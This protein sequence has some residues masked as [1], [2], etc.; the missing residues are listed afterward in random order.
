MI[1]QLLLLL[2]AG[3]APA[4][5]SHA[6]QPLFSTT[7]LPQQRCGSPPIAD[8]ELT[9]A[10][11][12]LLPHL[13]W[14]EGEGAA[15]NTLPPPRVLSGV[16]AGVNCTVQQWCEGDTCTEVCARGSVQV[17]RWLS[18]AI[19]Q[20]SRLVQT[21]PLCYA[22]LLGTHNS[23]ITLAD[24]YGALDEYFR[25]FFKYI[26]W[27]VKDFRDAPLHTNNQLL[28]LT[29][30][31]NL[32]VRSLEIDTHWVGGIL[33]I[34]H[35]GGLHM[36]QLNKLIEAINFIAKLLHR[37]IR[38]DTETLGCVP[39]LSSIPAMD[40]RLLTDALQ[41]V[42]D[43][44]DRP[45]NALEFVILYFDDQVNLQTWGVVGNLLADITGIFPS[46]WVYTT[47]DKAAHGPGWPSQQEMLTAGKRLL[48]VSGTD[49]GADMQP[50]IFSRGD[51]LCGWNEP[52]LASVNGVPECHVGGD[53]PQARPL[54]D[55]LLTR[56]ISCELVYGPLNCDFVWRGTNQP[57]FDEL[58]LPPVMGCGLNMPSPDLLTPVR[59]AAAIWTWAPGHPFDPSYGDA[60]RLGELLGA[61]AGGSGSPSDSGV[62][63]SSSSGPL[64]SSRGS[65]VQALAANC[66]VISAADARW[67]AVPCSLPALPSACRD[68]N[69]SLGAPDGGW[70]V[71]ASLPRGDC[72]PG[73]QYDLPRHP[74]ENYLLAAA[75]QRAGHEAAWLPV[76]G[77][78]WSTDGWPAERQQRQPTDKRRV[79]R[80]VALPAAGGLLAVA[81]LVAG[82]VLGRRLWL[83]C[84]RGGLYQ[85][86]A[87]E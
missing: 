16:P 43:W 67:R 27:A 11:R 87:S 20:Q 37:R 32:G 35:C 68:R 5:S 29:D 51:T 19:A 53:D 39:S 69:A 77:P 41:E 65:S 55:G 56:V 8:L 83:R 58:T 76:H 81:A 52:S 85:A 59:A 33:R 4:S 74:R 22:S 78:E 15:A 71:D 48:L 46:D 61:T 30:Q 73:T 66:G 23:A 1:W 9:E 64:G 36:P 42:K 82:T 54:F 75:L 62:G 38:W 2:L 21:L 14:P 72:P 3:L 60:A 25:G 13:C 24:G 12:E 47:E 18:H 34:A 80:H 44:M 6:E 57:V 26:K 45:E 70:V 28:S 63:S 84:R 49:Y 79:L 7:P 40:Q 10:E 50:L 17:E 86:L 31:L